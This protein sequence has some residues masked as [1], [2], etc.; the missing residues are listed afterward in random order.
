VATRILLADGSDIVAALVELCCRLG[1][2][3]LIQ[4]KRIDWDTHTIG[5]PGHTTDKENR[6]IPFNPNGRLA[7]VLSRRGKLGPNAFVF[8]TENSEYVASFK[9]AWESLLLIAN[10]PT[11]S[12]QSPVLAWIASSCIRSTCISTICVTKATVGSWQTAP[13]SAS[14]S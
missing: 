5:M 12:A 7:T 13:T 2:M 4:N 8:G 11:R 10:G 3:L 14:S 1:E 9:T 6:R